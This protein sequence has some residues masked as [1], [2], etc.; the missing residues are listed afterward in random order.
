MAIHPIKKYFTEL[1]QNSLHCKGQ[2][3]SEANY[4]FLNS[5]K[6]RTKK[7][8]PSSW[9]KILKIFCSSFGRI[10]NRIICFWNLSD[11]SYHLKWERC[12]LRPLSQQPLSYAS[13]TQHYVVAAQTLEPRP[14][15][16]ISRIWK[17][18]CWLYGKFEHSEVV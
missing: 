11:L 13:Y 5:S 18:T 1:V 16:L 3:I 15:V 2:I 6:K 8:C 17:Q 14:K 12:I 4:P 10:E 7:F 9:G